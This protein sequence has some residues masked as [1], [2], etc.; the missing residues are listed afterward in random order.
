VCQVVSDGLESMF[1]EGKGGLPGNNNAVGLRSLEMWNAM[2]IFPV[3][4]QDLMLIGTPKMNKSVMHMANGNDFIIR[5]EG[6][7]IYVEQA[8]LNGVKLADMSF[9]VSEMMKGGELVLTMSETPC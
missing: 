1:S 9:A 8:V 7:G 4:G 6:K 5:R 2:G 3:S